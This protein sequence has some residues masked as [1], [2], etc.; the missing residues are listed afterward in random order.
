MPISLSMDVIQEEDIAAE[1][2]HVAEEQYVLAEEQHIAFEEQFIAQQQQYIN[3]LHERFTAQKQFMASDQQYMAYE[4]QYVT[5]DQ[6]YIAPGEQHMDDI[7]RS[8]N[9]EPTNPTKNTTVAE[10]YEK[11]SGNPS[12]RLAEIQIAD[13]S[14]ESRSAEN[15]DSGKGI[16][17]S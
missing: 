7:C 1:E 2:M 9:A 13:P 4:E 8:I 6:Q 10:Y 5:P 15:C 14:D 16:I 11:D 3:M 12:P 17:I